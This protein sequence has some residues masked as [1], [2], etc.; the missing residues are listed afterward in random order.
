MK[1]IFTLFLLAAIAFPQLSV[2]KEKTIKIGKTVIYTGEVA[3]KKTPSGVGFIVFNN[4]AKKATEADTIRGL[5]S[6]RGEVY[7]VS[8]AVASFANGAKFI[9][10]ASIR[11]ETLS[12]KPVAEKITCV[13]DGHLE[14]PGNPVVTGTFT[15]NRTTNCGNN[16]FELALD[17]F[18]PKE[19]WTMVYHHGA[20]QGELKDGIIPKGKGT[21]YVMAS[22]HFETDKVI[23]I[24][25]GVFDGN[26][27]TNAE[28]TFNSGYRFFG[29]LE[30]EVSEKGDDEI[31]TYNLNG[32]LKDN[33]GSI[34][35][36]DT[37]FFLKRHTDYSHARTSIDDFNGTTIIRY[38]DKEYAHYTGCDTL[39][40]SMRLKLSERLFGKWNRD[41]GFAEK[42]PV[43]YY[44][45]GVVITKIQDG[46]S[47][48]RKDASFVVKNNRLAEFLRD[49]EEGFFHYLKDGQSQIIFKDGSRYDG[50]LAISSAR[51][52]NS[53][54]D[55]IAAYIEVPRMNDYRIMY[56]EGTTIM[57]NGKKEIWKKGITDYQANKISGNYE[58]RKELLAEMLIEEAKAADKA[59][60]DARPLF[61]KDFDQRYVDALYGYRLIEGMPL[62]MFKRVKEMGL[63]YYELTG[64]FSIN[65]GRFNQYVIT[66][67]N[68]QTGRMECQKTIKFDIF[69]RLYSIST[70][71]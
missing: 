30:C 28:M 59:W 21:L 41:F 69:N 57:A 5:F 70:S 16:T 48:D 63:P 10:D 19:V 56:L 35:F 52:C 18:D 64:P 9:G 17:T 45:N 14:W 62:S 71:F 26:T 49:Y 25:E 1:K 51:N 61:E 12:E 53:V 54:E 13:L 7:E 65:H 38:L 23:D 24:V 37:A 29:D 46:V 44:S 55:E 2:A 50:T 22:N 8:D 66:M 6:T 20:Y 39:E 11:F 60:E 68:R 3:D 4:Q 33:E 31:Y 32:V 47:V 15:M 34:M 58:G 42:E 67:W 40:V 43:Y 36:C 27:V